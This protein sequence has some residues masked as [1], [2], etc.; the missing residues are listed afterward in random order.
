MEEEPHYAKAKW[1]N[2]LGVSTSGYYTWIQERDTRIPRKDQLRADVK[3][4]FEEGEGAYG[5][6]RICNIL[7]T[8]GEKASFTVVRAIMAEE[9]IRSKHCV[10]RQRSLTDSSAARDDRYENHVKNLDITKRFQV[11]S[12]DITYIRTAQGFE[13]LCQIM[14]VY[15]KEVLGSAQASHMKSELV[16]EAIERA[17][18]RYDLGPGT[19][20]HSDRGS[21]YTSKLITETVAR[22]G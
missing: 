12:S 20:F 7:R 11:L 17:V 4:I 10:R 19:I 18:G 21:Q 13:Y 2:I 16:L 15:T 5:A 3:R 14:D 6:E 22:L 9:K 8:E 1:A